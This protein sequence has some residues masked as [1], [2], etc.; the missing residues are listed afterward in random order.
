MQSYMNLVVLA[1][2]AFTVSP[3]LSAPTSYHT[4]HDPGML[5]AEDKFVLGASALGLASIAGLGT[6]EYRKLLKGE[7]NSSVG[8]PPEAPAS[9]DMMGRA[10]GDQ[11]L[12]K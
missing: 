4:Y 2:A 1:L 3:A 8:G 6:W 10:L 7:G 5:G 12:D 9:P 11:D